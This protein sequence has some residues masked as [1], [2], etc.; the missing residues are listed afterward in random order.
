MSLLICVPIHGGGVAEFW[1]S[2]NQSQLDMQAVGFDHDLLT[3][4]NESLIPRARDNCVTSFLET[5]YE[6]MMFI[7]ADIEF[8]ASDI[9]AL[10]NLD[11][12]VAVGGY[13]MKRPDAP[14]CGWVNG[15]LI[16]I[17]NMDG[18]S[19]VDFA[20]TGFMMIKRDVFLR[21]HEAF[22]ERFH[23]EGSPREQIHSRRKSFLYFHSRLSDGEIWQDRIRWPEDYAFCHDFRQIGGKIIMDPSI[24]LKHWGSFGYGT[25]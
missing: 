6:R 17:G 22:P 13:P 25:S 1:E 23:A 9:S 11:V 5:N 7:D 18:P 21:M 15:E 3:M 19:E 24:K 2:L 20:G 10:W 14:T 12:D 8:T 4:K 16:D